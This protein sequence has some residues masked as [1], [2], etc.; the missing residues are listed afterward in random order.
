MMFLLVLLIVAVSVFTASASEVVELDKLVTLHH[1]KQGNATVSGISLTIP[2]SYP[3]YK[4]CNDAWGNEMMGDKTVCAVGCLMSSTSSGIGGTGIEIGNATSNPGTLNEWLKENS[5]YQNNNFVEGALPALNPARISW[6][7]DGMHPTNDLPYNTV[8]DYIKQGRVVIGNVMAGGH[9]VL[10]TGYSETDGDT[11]AVN[12]SGF[13]TATY[14]Y[15]KDI[16]GYR[17]FDMLREE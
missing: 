5:G 10:L 7:A 13:N 1:Q 14:S 6:P 2:W 12:D 4:Q 8:C 15:T 11:F 17:I 9:F 16:V 3:L